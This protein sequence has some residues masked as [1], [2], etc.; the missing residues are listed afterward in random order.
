[1]PTPDQVERL[2]EQQQ[3]TGELQGRYKREYAQT[4]GVLSGVIDKAVVAWEALTTSEAELKRRMRALEREQKE[5]EDQ[6]MID[7]ATLDD[8][9]YSTNEWGLLPGYNLP[10]ADPLS[11]EGKRV[12]DTLWKEYRIPGWRASNI[13]HNEWIKKYREANPGMER[14][15]REDKQMGQADAM[16]EAM[17]YEDS[18][19]RRKMIDSPSNVV[20]ADSI[21][22]EPYRVDVYD[23]IMSGSPG[24]VPKVANPN[25]AQLPKSKRKNEQE[26]SEPTGPSGP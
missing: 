23:T 8:P 13:L 18:L 12:I 21:D 24:R 16:L 20:M 11:V 4:R 19:E 9:L 22:G 3:Q 14:P 10:I 26:N 6:A 15:S 7:V 1:M 2:R 5:F 25:I 17:P